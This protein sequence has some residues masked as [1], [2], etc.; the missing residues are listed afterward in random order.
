MRKKSQFSASKLISADMK[1]NFSFTRRSE[2][3]TN[4]ARMFREYQ[5][6]AILENL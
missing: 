1:V 4:E 2:K 6:E 3:A 5:S